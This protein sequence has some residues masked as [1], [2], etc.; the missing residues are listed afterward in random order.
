MCVPGYSSNVCGDVVFVQHR[1][2]LLG[3]ERNMREIIL[4]ADIERNRM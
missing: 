2:K 4:V 3:A 1:V